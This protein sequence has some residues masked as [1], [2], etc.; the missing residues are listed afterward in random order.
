[1]YALDCRGRSSVVLEGGPRVEGGIAVAPRT[2]GRFAG[3]LIAPD[4]HRGQLF[5][6][7]GRGRTTRMLPRFR[8][9][10]GG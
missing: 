7:D 3:R 5:A 6:I 1:M 10:Y 2:F 8:F 4:E 9:P